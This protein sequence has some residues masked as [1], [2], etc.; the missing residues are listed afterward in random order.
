MAK[1]VSAL[2]RGADKT[3]PLWNLDTGG[4]TTS[5]LAPG[6]YVSTVAFALDGSRGI[7][8]TGSVAVA[9]WQLH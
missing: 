4:E 8:G 7:F 6:D 2:S 9:L 1:G 3:L 5:A